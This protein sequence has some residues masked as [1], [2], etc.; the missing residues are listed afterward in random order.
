MYHDPGPLPKLDT[1]NVNNQLSEFYK[2]NMEMVIAYSAHLSP[3]DGV[4]W[5][6]SPTGIGNVGE[7]PNTFKE[8]QN[9]M[10]QNLEQ[11][12]VKD[13]LKIQLLDKLIN[14]KL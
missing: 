6:I 14:R 1:V 5:D 9:S 12:W 13:M 3:D 4:K 7:L 2:W 8:Y 11:V 10:M